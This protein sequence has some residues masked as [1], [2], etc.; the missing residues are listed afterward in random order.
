VTEGGVLHGEKLD[1]S[2]KT[3]PWRKQEPLS[4]FPAA[5]PGKAAFISN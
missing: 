5:A 4:L 1:F 2:G 3:L